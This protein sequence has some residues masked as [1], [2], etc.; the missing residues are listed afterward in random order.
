MNR[1]GFF[2]LSDKQFYIFVLYP[3][4]FFFVICYVCVFINIVK[5]ILILI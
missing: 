2:D 4:F 3:T 5:I 1:V